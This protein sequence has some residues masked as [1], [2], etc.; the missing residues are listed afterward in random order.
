MLGWVQKVCRK[1]TPFEETVDYFLTNQPQPVRS[2]IGNLLT[3]VRTLTPLK[4]SLLKEP[5]E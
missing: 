2:R 1:K 3:S 4:A 5:Q